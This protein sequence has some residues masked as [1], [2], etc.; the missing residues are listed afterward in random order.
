MRLKKQLFLTTLII[1]LLL[2]GPVQAVIAS[3]IN[4]HDEPVKTSMRLP[5]GGRSDL[6]EVIERVDS[7]VDTPDNSAPEAEEPEASKT[8]ESSSSEAT[9]STE[10]STDTIKTDDNNTDKSKVKADIGPQAITNG[11]NGNVDWTFDTANGALTFGAGLTQNETLSERIK[12]NVQAAGINIAAVRY[13]DFATNGFVCAPSNMSRLFADLTALKNFDNL[14]YFNTQNLKSMSYW[15]ENCTALTTPNLNGLDTSGVTDMSYTF[16]YCG[17]QTLDLSS[18]NVQNVSNFSHMFNRLS[19]TQLN[20]SNWSPSQATNV[21]MS[22]MFADTLLK[23][24]TLTNFNTEN[25]TNMSYMFQYCTELTNLDLS[26]WNVDNVT[27]FANMFQY[28]NKITNLNLS[29]WGANR[30]ADNVDMQYMLHSTGKLSTLTLN[31]FKTDNV[32]NMSYMFYSSGVKSLDL[33]TWNVDN[34]TTFTRMFSYTASLTELNLSN[35]GTNRS[36]IDVDMS[37]MFFSTTKLKTLK[38]DDFKTTNVINMS[39]TFY[40]TGLTSLNL[41]GWDVTAVTNFNSMFRNTTSLQKLDLSDW[42]MAAAND[43]GRMF[44]NTTSLWQIKLGTGASFPSDP[45]FVSPTLNQ[46]F[47]DNEQTYIVTAASWQKVDSGTVHNPTGDLVTIE[48]MAITPAETVT[49]VWV[50]QAVSASI[51]TVSA[52]TFGTVSASA[53]TNNAQPKAT[54]EATGKVSLIDLVVNA[55]NY[56]ITVQQTSDWQAEGEAAT[57]S[58]NDLAINYGTNNLANG[59]ANFWSGTSTTKTINVLFN[60]DDTKNFNIGL[61]PNTVINSELLGKQ[62]ES[63]LTWTLS[64]TP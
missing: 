20:L 27:T 52:L 2:T 45:V 1:S 32:T 60:H 55:D 40:N 21:D 62:L 5:N 26:S 53:F 4:N 58:K 28:V 24:L 12:T 11:T 56:D 39:S 22:Y 57:I 23:T 10:K 54:N 51:D 30:S 25:V 49:Y 38:L 17:L 33:T 34:V 43:T 15:F 18:W 46:R 42:N 9:T 61:N 29:N 36:A 35:W 31:N 50:H 44:E 13:I 6:Q 16:Y 48:E 41:N 59:A 19:I 47:D 3:E 37:N 14:A 64:E 7:Q 63:E 8:E